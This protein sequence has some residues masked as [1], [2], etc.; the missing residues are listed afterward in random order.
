[1]F[2]SVVIVRSS[3]TFLVSTLEAHLT[4]A[5]YNVEAIFPDIDEI[6]RFSNLIV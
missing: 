2:R 4:E 5:H 1:M 3:E 6:K